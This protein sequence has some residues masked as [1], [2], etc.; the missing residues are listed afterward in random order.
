M[1]KFT[2]TQRLPTTPAHPPCPSPPTHAEAMLKLWQWFLPVNIL[3]GIPRHGN[4]TWK[5]DH[6]AIQ[7]FLWTWSNALTRTDAF[8]EA[9]Q[10]CRT[11]LGTA[12]LSTYQGFMAALTKWSPQLVA[13]LIAALRRHAQDIGGRFW[14]VGPWVAIAFDG[15]R[16]AAPRTRSNEA[17]YNPT[18]YG[19]GPTA[20]YRKKKDPGP[21]LE[22][23]V[24]EQASSPST[25]SV[26]HPALARGL[27]VALGVAVGA[28]QLQRA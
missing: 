15:S 23:Q 10:Q 22:E 3:S 7:A 26:D 8:D 27:A 17:A 19:N 1:L 9:T 24:E 28:L 16:A 13:E 21:V 5:P 4:C 11:L 20:T 6:V 25:P 14:R 2:R 18:D 12:A